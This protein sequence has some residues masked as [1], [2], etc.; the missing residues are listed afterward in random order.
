MARFH[1]QVMNGPD[2]AKEIR[3]I[4]PETNIVG[5]T[6]NML[7]EDV[8]L[9]KAS[10]A[11]EVMGKPFKMQRLDEIWKQFGILAD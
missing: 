7:R 1:R 6:G 9:F 3:K 5:I 11:N 2:A 4:S 8:A 10:G